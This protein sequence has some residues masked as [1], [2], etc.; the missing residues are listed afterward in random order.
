M[1]WLTP[2]LLTL[3][4]SLTGIGHAQPWR[5]ELATWSA[6]TR[7]V[8]ELIRLTGTV[9]ATA[10]AYYLLMHGWIAGFGASPT[11]L[12]L[13]SVLAMAGTAGLTAV[14][15][16]R[17]LGAPAGL[18]AGLLLAV[19]PSTSRYAQEARPYAI[20]S[21]LAVLATLL[22][23]RALD[24][25]TWARWAGYAAVVVA[26]GLAHLLALSL[27]APHAVVVV[28]AWWRGRAA[29][30]LDGSPH[31]A[32]RPARDEPD[33][34][35]P[36][37]TGA[38]D[39]RLL[40]WPLALLVAGVLLLPL[41]STARGQ[42]SRQLDWIEPARLSDLSALPGA[43]AE[44]SVVGGLLVGLAALGAGRVGRRALLPGACVLLP[45][46]LLYLAALAVPL[47]VPRYLLF[48]VPFACLLAGA[49]LATVPAPAA[50]AVLTLAG[51]L[52]LPDQEALRR[53]HPPAGLID[54]RGAA[55]LVAAGQRPGDAVVYSPRDGWLF[56]DLGMAYHLGEDRPRDALLVRNQR[57]RGDF[58]ASECARPAECLAGVQRVWL[59]VSGR[60]SDPLAAVGGAKG[61]TLRDGFTVERVWPRPGVTVAL[62]N[63]P[64]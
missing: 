13:P 11:A 29:A 2:T 3:A 22:L 38:R 49:A 31:S 42:R 64:G 5:D 24:R 7:P 35:G 54:Y 44:S 19:L 63:R 39:G 53:A 20:A 23:V 47:W 12:R 55:Q 43:V 27:L 33:P 62:L 45:V 37:R 30:G 6:A 36:A 16:R 51:L 18:L 25:P 15:G 28:V 58:W 50:L 52:G 26:L 8:R 48:T 32:E 60:R 17:L 10:G 1:V 40:R 57:Q 56:F 61:R 46:L 34:G 4:I 9:D 14:L 41:L 59:V 21:L